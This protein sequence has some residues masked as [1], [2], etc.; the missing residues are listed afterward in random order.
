MIL[1][2]RTAT[3]SGVAARAPTGQH[4]SLGKVSY[5]PQHRPGFSRAPA[6]AISKTPGPVVAIWR[7]VPG[8]IALARRW[9]VRKPVLG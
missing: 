5:R 7:F 3:F 8:T 9:S 6:D 4:L 1:A 2:W